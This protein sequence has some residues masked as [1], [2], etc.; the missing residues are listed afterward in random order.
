MAGSRAYLPEAKGRPTADFHRFNQ[1]RTRS[2]GVAK[3]TLTV[4]RALE[5]VRA[6]NA[7]ASTEAV[8]SLMRGKSR[9]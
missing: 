5:A 8:P 2:I 1:L 3:L 9:G 4:R 6:L 7:I